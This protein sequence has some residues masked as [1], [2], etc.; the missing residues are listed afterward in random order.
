MQTAI[1]IATALGQVP[2][3]KKRSP[4]RTLWIGLL[5]PGRE[6][7]RRIEAFATKII[8]QGLVRETRVIRSRVGRKRVH[9]F[10][11]EYQA[12]LAYL[13]GRISRTEL[14]DRLTRELL[15]YA[16]RQM[17]WFKRNPRIRWL[18]TA[19]AAERAV[20]RFISERNR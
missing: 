17:R 9:E 1:E 12:A 6:L 3:I 13:T 20:R 2:K 10:G 11:F 4:Y 16:R 5:P 15:G 19:G 8:R 7:A 14:K 18:R